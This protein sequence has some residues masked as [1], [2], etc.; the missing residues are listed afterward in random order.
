MQSWWKM[1]KSF[2]RHLQ[3]VNDGW[4][5]V[6]VTASSTIKLFQSAEVTHFVQ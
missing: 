4:E 3:D 1:G 2:F 6:E 5:E